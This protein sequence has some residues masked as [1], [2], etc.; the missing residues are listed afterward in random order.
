MLR[1][2]PQRNVGRDWMRSLRSLAAGVGSLGGPFRQ[3]GGTCARARRCRGRLF[4]G[5]GFTIGIFSE[6]EIGEGV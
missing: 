6:E 3:A 1:A 4:L 5:G 2:A